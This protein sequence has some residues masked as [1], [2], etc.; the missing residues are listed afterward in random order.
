MA[1]EASL[2]MVNDVAK[3]TLTGE[4]D[5]SVA[6]LFKEQIEAAAQKQAKR[7]VLL[8]SNL[9]Y[10]SSAGL[11]VL[12]FAKQKMG[13]QVVIYVVGAQPQIV[14]PI[15]Q[16]GFHYSVT[17]MDTYDAAVIEAV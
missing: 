6:G 2:E 10:M 17:M 16:T 3:I 12:V 8:M 9:E 14:E 11:R 1:F 4:L 13:T 5:A 7:L 15:K